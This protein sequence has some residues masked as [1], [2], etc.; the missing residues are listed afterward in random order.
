M[1]PSEVRRR[2]LDD[3][4]FLRVMLVGLEA[5]AQRVLEG[6][7]SLLGPLRLEGEALLSRLAEHMHWEDVSLRPALLEADAWGEAR[8]EKL[9]QDHEEQR[10]MLAFVLG[11][12]RDQSRPRDV[13]A[14]T[15]LDLVRLLREDMDDEEQVLLDER[16]LRDDVVAIDAESG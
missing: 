12:I 13:I 14:R 8:A 7:G 10:E 15:L 4:E 5:T 16:V 2:I 11:S 3:H 6:E 1:Q 9:D